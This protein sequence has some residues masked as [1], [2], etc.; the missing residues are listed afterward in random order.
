MMEK[1]ARSAQLPWWRRWLDWLARFDAVM[2][3]TYDD[4]QDRRIGDIEQRLAQLE[5]ETRG[6]RL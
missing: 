3:E 1:Q 6:E 4:I 5:A 2:H